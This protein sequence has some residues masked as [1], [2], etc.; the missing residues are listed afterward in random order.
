MSSLTLCTDASVRDAQPSSV[1]TPAAYLLFYRRRSAQPLGGANFRQLLSAAENEHRLSIASSHSPGRSPAASDIE[2]DDDDDSDDGLNYTSSS[3]RNS[4]AVIGPELPPAVFYQPPSVGNETLWGSSMP[5][6][7]RDE[8]P[9]PNAPGDDDS[10]ELPSYEQSLGVDGAAATVGV[11][12]AAGNVK[13][14]MKGLAERSLDVDV[15][16]VDMEEGGVGVASVQKD[17]AGGADGLAGIPSV[18]V[19]TIPPPE[20]G[21]DEAVEVRL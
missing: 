9:T 12:G 2:L 14:R 4:G 21:D 3:A 6:K 10:E 18:V 15:D 17:G 20:D 19:H 5:A 1:V 7:A 11:G 8:T 16:D 13:E